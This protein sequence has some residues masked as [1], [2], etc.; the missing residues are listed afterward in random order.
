MPSEDSDQPGHPPSLIRVFA[1]RMKKAWVLSYPLN[2]QRRLRS[3]W[4][5]AQADLSLRW[6][7]M[8]FCWFCHVAA[9][10]LEKHIGQLSL[11]QARHKRYTCIKARLK[12][13]HINCLFV[14]CFFLSNSNTPKELIAKVYQ[15]HDAY[16]DVCRMFFRTDYS[17]KYIRMF[18]R[19]F[20]GRLIKKVY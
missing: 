6:A 3:A 4:A 16:Q 8:P 10:M 14:F 13:Y 9:Q 7:H 11:P 17:R 19:C 5:D 15:L 1:V 20:Q 2:A 18:I 12:R